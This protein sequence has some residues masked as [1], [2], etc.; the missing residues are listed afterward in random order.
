MNGLNDGDVY[1]R[2]YSLVGRVD[3]LEKGLTKKN[4]LIYH[5]VEL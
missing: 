3:K 2:I 4:L 5:F 1:R